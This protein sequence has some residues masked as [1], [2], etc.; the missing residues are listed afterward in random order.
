MQLLDQM[1]IIF[2]LNKV[3]L[4][5]GGSRGIGSAVVEM[6]A[7]YGNK[8]YYIS[9][10]K[11]NNFISDNIVYIYGDISKVNSLL[12]AFEKL[13][14]YEKKIDI[15]INSAGINFC[16]NH[17]LISVEEWDLVFATNVRSFFIS[18]KESIKIMKPGSKIVNI[19][20]IAAR[21]KSLV[22]GVHY[23]AS[24]WAIIGLTKQL[25]HECG[26]LGININCVCPSQTETDMLMESMSEDD[27]F[28]L[29]KKIPLQRLAKVS[30]IVG[31]ILFLCSD[32]SKYIHGSCIDI[33]G[34]QI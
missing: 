23:T 13:S 9:R 4:V 14:G 19:S 15:L 16:K 20:S 3:V 27:R 28:N 1:L 8:V 22:S 31:P 11:N 26:T 30:D 25:A 24:K 12:K 7:A 29:S 21:N 5:V 10:N 6:F 2:M 33:N 18:C 32:Q 17:S 34:G